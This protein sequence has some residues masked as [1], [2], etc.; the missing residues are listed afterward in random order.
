[1]KADIEFSAENIWQAFD[2]L[3][4]HF[5]NLRDGD[6]IDHHLIELGRIQIEPKDQISG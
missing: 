5:K 4:L 3:V 6:D 1:M 2:K